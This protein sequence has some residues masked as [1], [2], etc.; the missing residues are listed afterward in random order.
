[1]NSRVRILASVAV[2]SAE[3]LMVA[4][5]ASALSFPDVPLNHIYRD[6]IDQLSDKNIIKGNPDGTF[7]PGK[8][9]NRAEMLTML[10]RATGKSPTVPTKACFKDV[11]AGEWYS[12]VICDASKNGYVAGYSDGYFRPEKEVNRVEALKMI[13]TVFGFTL[14]ANASLTPL[15]GYS[16]VSL[17]AWYAAYMANGF[18]KKVLPIAGQEGTKFYPEWALLRGEAAAYIFNALGLTPR[19]SQR[20]SS[21]TAAARSSRSA[22][23]E[24]PQVQVLDVDFP[25]GDDGTFAG[26]LGKAYVFKL[27]SPVIASFEVSVDAGDD[28]SVQCR[29]YKLDSGTSFAIEYYIGHM[30]GNKCSMRVS[31]GNGNYQLEL[32]PRGENNLHYE[33]KSKTVSGD[34]NDGFREASMLT[35]GTPKTGYL[36]PEDFAEWYY[37]KVEKQGKLTVEAT[38]TGNDVRCL[39][40][41]MSDVDLYGFSGPVCGEEY[42]YPVGTYYIGIQRRDDRQNEQQSFTVRYY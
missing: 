3:L 14:N 29:L 40:Y 42:E 31:L 19:T 6:Q 13:H 34:G 24:V 39:I 25:F 38:G 17:T 41:P 8:T 30:V 36:E 9:V 37:F 35:K 11:G 32:T 10:Y 5:P 15:K 4:W 18:E 1:M 16:D 23:S 7:M 2:L 20:S 27:K 28:R 22:A 21:S 26:K 33:L 12:S